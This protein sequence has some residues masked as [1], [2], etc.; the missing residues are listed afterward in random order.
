MAIFMFLLII[1]MGAAVDL[2]GQMRSMQ[3]ADDVARE[4]GRQGAQALDVDAAMAGNAQQVDPGM[5][6]AAA[7]NYLASAGV[8]G[9]VSVQ[10]GTLLD[11]TTATTYQPVFLGIIGI[12]ELNASGHAQVQL[13]R[14][15][16]GQER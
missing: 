14:V 11:V 5:A 1:I 8:T 9:Q 6:R 15:V 7:E 4:A 10:A 12:G 2:G 3:K 16:N 13:I